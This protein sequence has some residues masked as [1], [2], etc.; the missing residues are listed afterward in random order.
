MT[1]QILSTHLTQERALGVT[2][3][4]GL[5]AWTTEDRRGLDTHGQDLPPDLPVGPGKSRSKTMTRRREVPDDCISEV[6]RRVGRHPRRSLPQRSVKTS[7]RPVRRKERDKDQRGPDGRRDD[8]KEGRRKEKGESRENFLLKMK[9]TRESLRTFV[10]Y[11]A[12]LGLT[13]TR[14]PGYSSSEAGVSAGV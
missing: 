6:L 8:V 4:L 5:R 3:T 13:R 9:E 10:L 12:P 2:R 14:S 1:S 7:T 11:L